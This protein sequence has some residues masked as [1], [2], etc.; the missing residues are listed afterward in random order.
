MDGWQRI[1]SE[2]IFF[3]LG[4]MQAFP[5][6]LYQIARY[7]RVGDIRPTN[8]RHGYT[9]FGSSAPVIYLSCRQ[10]NT[11]RYFV[12]AHELAHVM[13]R[14]PRVVDFLQASGQAD[15]LTDE[16]TLADSIAATI[17]MPDS[18]IENLRG[19]RRPLSQLQY[20]A[21]LANVSVATLVARMAASNVD[22]ALLHWRRSNGVWHVIDRPG[23]PPVLHGYVKPSNNGH[24]AIENLLHEESHLVIDCSINGRIAK[25]GGRGFRHDEHAFHFLEPSVDIWIAPKPNRV[26]Q[27]SRASANGPSSRRLGVSGLHPRL[28]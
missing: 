7:I 25:I 4:G 17:L 11:R 24:R 26:K 9:D 1:E 22:I 16:E 20:A 18:L 15:L 27:N 23:T 3:A 10:L 19:P 28:G 5:V 13:L 8:Y 21:R 6:D 12:L 2:I 14:I